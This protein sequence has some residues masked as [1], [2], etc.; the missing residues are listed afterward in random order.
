MIVAVQDSVAGFTR[1]PQEVA[2]PSRVWNLKAIGIRYCGTSNLI[3]ASNCLHLVNTTIMIIATILL[4]QPF[5]RKLVFQ[6]LPYIPRIL[7]MLQ[8]IYT[9][10]PCN[11]IRFALLTSAIIDIH[12]ALNYIRFIHS[13]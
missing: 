8:L 6:L 9:I 1:T 5:M 11:Y 2:S 3:T 7:I 10:V 4:H 12:C 13:A